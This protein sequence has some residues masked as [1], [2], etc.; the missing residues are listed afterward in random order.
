MKD[1]AVRLSKSFLM[2]FFC[3]ILIGSLPALFQG[4]KLAP[5]SYL[6]SLYNV[7]QDI[8]AAFA[9]GLCEPHQCAGGDPSVISVYH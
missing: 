1:T 9:F 7:I 6:K 3:I 8:L 4:V 2:T 5:G